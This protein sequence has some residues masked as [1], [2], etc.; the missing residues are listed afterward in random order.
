[1]LER[2]TNTITLAF[3]ECKDNS[4]EKLKT[5]FLHMRPIETIID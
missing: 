5:L 1:M 2:Q 3:I 4:F